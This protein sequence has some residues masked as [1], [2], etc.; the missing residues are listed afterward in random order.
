[1][2]GSRRE[3]GTGWKCIY[4]L[5]VRSEDKMDTSNTNREVAGNG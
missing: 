2:R 3:G 5:E 1:M 4:I